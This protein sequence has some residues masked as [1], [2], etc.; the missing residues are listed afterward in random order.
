[1]DASPESVDG[2]LVAI[3]IFFI[4]A[5]IIA[6]GVFA[7]AEIAI[8]SVRKVRLQQKAEDGDRRA[9]LVLDLA[10]N[11]NRFLSTT[12]IG[13]TLIGIFAGAFGG[14]TLAGVLQTWLARFSF[15]TPYAEELSLGVVVLII[16]YLSLVLGELVPKRIALTHPEGIA[17]RMAGPMNGLSRIASPA[18]SLLSRSTDVLL[19]ALGVRHTNDPP[20]TEDEISALIQAGTDA[21]VFEE[22]EQELVERVFWLGD[23]RIGALMTPRNRIVWLDIHEP[24]EQVRQKMMENRFARFPVGDKSLDRL[25]GMVQVT[26]LWA[27]TL[28]GEPLDNWTHH[29]RKPLFV[30]ATLRALRL[31]ELFRTSGVHLAIVVD[32]YGGT[33]GLVTLNDL[34]EE[35]SGDLTM[36]AE[37]SVVRRDDGSFLV[38]GTLTMDEVW[39][40]LDLEDR[41]REPRGPYNTLGGFIVGEMGRIPTSGQFVEAFGLRFEV[42]DMDGNRVDKVLIRHLP[43]ADDEDDD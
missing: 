33:E 42:V 27:A 24:V 15:L 3:Q 25:V 26:E 36:P 10:E 16:T 23:Q 4:V 20:V 6:N 30:P 22:E 40:E 35:I 37:P 29:Q 21:G 13:I 1:M 17:L 28:A 43:P 32:E 11:P 39:E 7:M 5:L 38:D 14:A 18:V 12:Q 8:V 2:S 31:L 9:Q 34:L 19:K 41:R